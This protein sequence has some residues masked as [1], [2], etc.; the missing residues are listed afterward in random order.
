MTQKG[1]YDAMI[2]VVSNFEWTVR[3]DGGFDCVTTLISTGVNI[4]EQ[5]L[6]TTADA[7]LSGL[8]MFFK[9]GTTVDEKVTNKKVEERISKK[10]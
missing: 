9:D 5:K 8:P 10:L 7:R 4:L 6:Q 3:D 2:G 1:N